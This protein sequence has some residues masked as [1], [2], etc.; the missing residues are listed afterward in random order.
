MFIGLGDKRI[1]HLDGTLFA[2][3]A[4]QVKVH[5]AEPDHSVNN[6]FSV[7]GFEP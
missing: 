5:D 6:I 4:V 7:Q 1:A 3:N 2:T